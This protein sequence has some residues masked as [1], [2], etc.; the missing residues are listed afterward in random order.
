VYFYALAPATAMAAS[1]LQ[2]TAAIDTAFNEMAVAV[3]ASAGVST[4]NVTPGASTAAADTYADGYAAVTDA[5]GQGQIFKIKSHA[6]IAS[7]TAFDLVLYDEIETALT[8]SST[9]SIV[10]NP[11]SAPQ[12][13]NTTVAEVP[14]GVANVAIGAN[15]YGWLQTAG[16][17]SC[18]FDEAVAIGQ[19]V[20]VGTGTAG[21]VEEDDT[22]TT[23]SQEFIVGYTLM[24]G[25][26]TE[27]QIVDLCI[28]Y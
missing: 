26:D 21:A 1:E 16:P 12:Q 14:V 10:A 5:A 28:R 13:S 11:Y 18:L 7:A 23:V 24:A 6:A 2:V 15:E 17:C 9:I 27:S 22:A 4:I 3:A 20:T 25:V 19:A 8:T